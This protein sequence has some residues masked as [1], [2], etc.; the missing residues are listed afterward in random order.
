[1]HLRVLTVQA[2]LT[3]PLPAADQAEAKCPL[4]HPL[5]AVLLSLPAGSAPSLL[6]ADRLSDAQGL[7]PAVLSVPLHVV[8]AQ[9]LAPAVLFASLHVVNLGVALAPPAT[10]PGLRPRLRLSPAQL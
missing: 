8:N 10:N 5:P 9:G 7:A 4:G 2:R 3:Q 6:A 1:M